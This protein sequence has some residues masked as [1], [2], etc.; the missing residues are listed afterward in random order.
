MAFESCGRHIVLVSLYKGKREST[1][2][3]KY[4]NIFTL[5]QMGEEAP[6]KKRG[7]DG[8]YREALFQILRM[9]DVV[10]KL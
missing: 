4:R 10:G 7:Y 1:K 9:F 2:F 3:K 6:E 8:F 5:K